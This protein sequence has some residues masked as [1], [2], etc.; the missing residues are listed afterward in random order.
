MYWCS[1][2]F[3]HTRYN[4]VKVCLSKRVENKNSLVFNFVTWR[5]FSL[6]LLTRT[7]PWSLT[8]VGD[9]NNC[10]ESESYSW[11]NNLNTSYIFSFT[12]TPFSKYIHLALFFLLKFLFP[13]VVTFF[14]QNYLTFILLKIYCYGS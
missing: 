13:S 4:L 3:S 14:N 11:Q 9:L 2:H 8:L 5:R 10:S 7:S 1:P 12:E 6:I